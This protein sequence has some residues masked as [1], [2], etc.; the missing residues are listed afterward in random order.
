MGGA[1]DQ[2]EIAD[3]LT[4]MHII[5]ARELHACLVRSESLSSGPA[6][7]SSNMKKLLVAREIVQ[8]QFIFLAKFSVNSS[9]SKLPLHAA[10]A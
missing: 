9:L 6:P 10:H 3:I 7:T 4:M 1:P 2:A 8:N 5:C